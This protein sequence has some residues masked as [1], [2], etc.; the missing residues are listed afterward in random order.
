MAGQCFNSTN[1]VNVGSITIETVDGKWTGSRFGSLPVG[2][3]IRCHKARPNQHGRNIHIIPDS[4]RFL[5]FCSS[6]NV[7][8]NG[9][10]GLWDATKNY[11]IRI[12][13]PERNGKVYVLKSGTYRL[14]ACNSFLNIPPGKHKVPLMKFGWGRKGI[15]HSMN[16]YLDVNVINKNTT[17]QLSPVSCAINNNKNMTISFGQLQANSG[18]HNQSYDVQVSCTKSA[19][20]SYNLFQATAQNPNLPLEVKTDQYLPVGL[21]VVNGTLWVSHANNSNPE[22]LSGKISYPQTQKLRINSRVNTD[23]SRIASGG[24]AI[25]GS[26]ILEIRID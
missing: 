22:K 19:S 16:Y 21:G 18:I 26:A 17:P 9:S 11:D 12:F 20:L 7:L 3:S 2:A 25:N 14:F 4:N 24:G 5:N 1:E 8:V 23:I 13:G 15:K 10:L 6:G